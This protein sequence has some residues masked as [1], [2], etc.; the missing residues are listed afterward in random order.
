[1]YRQFFIN[2]FVE[3][4]TYRAH[5]LLWRLRSIIAFLAVFFM[6]N[7]LFMQ[8]EAIAGFT[9][10]EMFT[11]V[12]L[13]AFLSMVI[14]SAKSGVI[15]D[16]IKDGT[17]SVYLMRP[18]GYFRSWFMRDAADKLFN[19]GA[20]ILELSVIIYLLAP[21]MSLSTDGVYLLLTMLSIC[22]AIVMFFVLQ[23]AVAMAAFWLVE[24][25][26]IRFVYIVLIQ[27]FAG[28]MFPLSIFPGILGAILQ[29]TPFAYLVYIPVM[30]YLG[31][32]DILQSIVQ[33]A[34]GILWCIVIW[35]GAH[36]LWKKG[37]RL[38]SAVGR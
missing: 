2:T 37:L 1:M 9:K 30:I 27:F 6:W 18:V 3:M 38:Y 32:Y 35:I 20:S 16:E 21:P 7:A 13:G 24:T 31:K 14:F 23:I 22:V 15:A 11:Y 10:P 25:W 33:I 36:I 5:F 17:L 4:F 28:V 34:I 26:P 12:I 8:R 19:I 29:Y